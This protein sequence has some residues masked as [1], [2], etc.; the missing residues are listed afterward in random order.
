MTVVNLTFICDRLTEHPDGELRQWSVQ[1]QQR[2][3]DPLNQ[4]PTP[5]VISPDADCPECGN[6]GAADYP[7]G[8]VYVIPDD[9]SN[10]EPVEQIREAIAESEV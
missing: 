5:V 7:D 8:T 2:I 3:M 10:R 4:Q 9:D 1:G 6:I